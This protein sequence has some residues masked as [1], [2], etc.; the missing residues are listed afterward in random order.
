MDQ[1]RHRILLSG[2]LL[3]ADGGGSEGM[4]AEVAGCGCG[5][6]EDGSGNCSS[7]DSQAVGT[8]RRVRWF[9]PVFA[10]YAAPNLT[11]TS[12]DTPGSCMVTP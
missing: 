10:P 8:A 6:A 9:V 4:S 11:D 7:N 3:A 12:F 2:K 1:L 5:K